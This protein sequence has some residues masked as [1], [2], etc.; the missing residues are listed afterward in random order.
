[1]K[2]FFYLPVLLVMVLKNMPDIV[3]VKLLCFCLLFVGSVCHLVT[4]YRDSGLGRSGK[5]LWQWLQEGWW[6]YL[7]WLWGQNMSKRFAII[8]IC[9]TYN[10]LTWTKLVIISKFLLLKK[11]LF[12]SFKCTICTF[13]MHNTFDFADCS[14][15]QQYSC[16]IWS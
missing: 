6:W 2:I 4:Q 3:S 5:K 8:V 15:M 1:M 14:R 16:H 13:I 12:P 11:I 9:Q 7:H 10:H